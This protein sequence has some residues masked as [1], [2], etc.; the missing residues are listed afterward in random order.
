MAVPVDPQEGHVPTRMIRRPGAED[1]EGRLAHRRVAAPEERERAALGLDIARRIPRDIAAIGPAPGALAPRAIRHDRHIALEIGLG[2][3]TRHAGDKTAVERGMEQQPVGPVL[4]MSVLRMG[5]PGQHQTRSPAQQNPDGGAP[6]QAVGH[7]NS[8]LCEAGHCR[9]ILILQASMVS[10]E[11]RLTTLSQR[12]ETKIAKTRGA[13]P[14]CIKAGAQHQKAAAHIVVIARH[15]HPAIKP[16]P[17]FPA[18]G[19]GVERYDMRL[20]AHA[21]PHHRAMGLAGRPRSIPYWCV[22]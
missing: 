19:A 13:L 5:H 6:G 9:L 16:V 20:V 22:T 4:R 14:G 3:P 12:P 11:A 15:F 10:P 18:I 7:G 2:L 21:H 1:H 17:G 8:P